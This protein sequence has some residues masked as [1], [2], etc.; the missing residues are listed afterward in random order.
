VYV[1]ACLASVHD[2][3][4][5]YPGNSHNQGSIYRGGGGGEA[6]HPKEKRERERGRE[7]RR[8]GNVYYLGVMIIHDIVNNIRRIYYVTPKNHRLA[9]GGN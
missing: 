7:R 9:G 8:S 2:K 1:D 3:I 4:N 5:H 6:S